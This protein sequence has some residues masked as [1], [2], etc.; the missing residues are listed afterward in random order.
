M[1]ELR[2]LCCRKFGHQLEQLVEMLECPADDKVKKNFAEV[3]MTETGTYLSNV[4]ATS[5]SLDVS[6][7]HARTI[8]INALFGPTMAER[9]KEAYFAQSPAIR[10]VLSSVAQVCGLFFCRHRAIAVDNVGRNTLLT[11]YIIAVSIMIW[12]PLKHPVMLSCPGVSLRD[13][14]GV[15]Q[16][17]TGVGNSLSPSLQTFCVAI[18]RTV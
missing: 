8:L 9:L 15:R 10:I 4:L 2:R 12:L 11:S 13:I 14:A 7:L 3:Y 6:E 17:K 5:W 1:L 18:L 16:F